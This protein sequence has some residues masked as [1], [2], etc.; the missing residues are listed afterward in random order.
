MPYNQWKMKILN[1]IHEIQ[2][3]EFQKRVWLEG[4]G[5]E[6]SSWD[7]T[8]CGLFDDYDIDGFLK[9]EL[10]ESGL[11]KNQYAELKK[12]RDELNIYCEQVGETP[13]VEYILSDPRWLQIRTAAEHVL[14]SFRM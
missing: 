6:V 9:L 2:D 1:T 4:K 12:L 7:E 11:S 13:T 3:A 8:M 5:P 14:K 10:N